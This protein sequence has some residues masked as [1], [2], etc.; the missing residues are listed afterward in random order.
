MSFMHPGC[1]MQVPCAVPFLK[2]PILVRRLD[3]PLEFLPQSLREELLDR[4][5][6]FFGED[7]CESRID[8]ILSLWLVLM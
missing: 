2:L 1:L 5:V 7:Y 4:D 3:R 6:E 8:V